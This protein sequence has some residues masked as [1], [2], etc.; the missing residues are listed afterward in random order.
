VPRRAILLALAAVAAVG[1]GAAVAVLSSHG[2]QRPAATQRTATAGN[3]EQSVVH[4]TSRTT[5]SA[6]VDNTRKGLSAG[7]VLTQHSVWY[8]GKDRA[9]T[10]ALTAT[11]TRRTSAQT[12][13]VMFTAVASVNQG[14]IV[15]TG[16]FDIVPQNQTFEAAVT[17]GTRGFRNAR[18]QAVFQQT[19]GTTTQVTLL[20]SS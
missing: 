17:G 2:G 15:M 3:V 9:G 1:L 13:E 18:G 7:D 5:K 4:F 6:Y 11:V 8:E 20:L 16:S 12:G 10:M 19:S 14:Q